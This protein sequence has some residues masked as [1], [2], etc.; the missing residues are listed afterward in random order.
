MDVEPTAQ[1]YKLQF[2]NQSCTLYLLNLV[3]VRN[4]I[5]THFQVCDLV[6][7]KEIIIDKISVSLDSNEYKMALK[8]HDE[9]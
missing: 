2:R 7:D 1:I 3:D 8:N 9:E 4:L 5:M 6:I